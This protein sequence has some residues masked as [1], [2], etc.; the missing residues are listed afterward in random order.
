MTTHETPI[1]RLAYCAAC[2]THTWPSSAYGCR[3]CGSPVLDAVPLPQDP[4]LLNFITVHSELAPNLPVPCVIGELELAPGVIEEALIGV[5]DESV[6]TVGMKLT[7]K[8]Q[9]D[10]RGVITWRFVPLEGALA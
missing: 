3:R 1:L 5:P 9:T 4:T 6:L 7:P 2:G 10:N 8:S